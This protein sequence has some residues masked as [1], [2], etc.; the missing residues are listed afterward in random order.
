M[1]NMQ[2]ETYRHVSSTTVY[3]FYICTEPCVRNIRF[4]FKHPKFSLGTRCKHLELSPNFRCPQ[5]LTKNKTVFLLGNSTACYD[6]VCQHRCHDYYRLQQVFLCARKF[7]FS[8]I[9]WISN[10]MSLNNWFCI[11]SEKNFSSNSTCDVFLSCVSST[12]PKKKEKEKWKKH[13]KFEN[14]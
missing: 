6:V 4:I 12:K 3:K 2:Q 5:T 11:E 10:V 1:R 9:L 8:Q 7:I 13:R 14:F